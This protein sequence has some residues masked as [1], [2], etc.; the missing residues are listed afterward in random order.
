MRVVSFYLKYLLHSL[1][2]TLATLG[3][4]LHI[5]HPFINSTNKNE[6]LIRGTI[7]GSEH[8]MN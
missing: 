1:P 4:I 2:S 5:Y 3:K 6:A 8:M 7:L